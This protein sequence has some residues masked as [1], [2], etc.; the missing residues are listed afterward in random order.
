MRSFRFTLA[1]VLILLAMVAAGSVLAPIAEANELAST[2]V[3]ITADSSNQDSVQAEKIRVRV[4]PRGGIVVTR[5]RR[6]R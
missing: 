2:T 1:F 6:R 3:K 4:T 5:R